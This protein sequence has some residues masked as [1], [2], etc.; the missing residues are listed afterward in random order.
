MALTEAK[1]WLDFVC[2]WVVPTYIFKDRDINFIGNFS[3]E[4]WKSD[5]SLRDIVVSI[6]INT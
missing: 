4:I 2:G 1:I 3:R 6:I 5:Y